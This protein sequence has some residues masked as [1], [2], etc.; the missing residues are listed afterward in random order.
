MSK[1]RLELGVTYGIIGIDQ[2]SRWLHM[3]DRTSFV[4]DRRQHPKTLLTTTRLEIGKGKR[5]RSLTAC[6]AIKT[7]NGLNARSK[8]YQHY[9][10]AAHALCIFSGID[11]SRMPR[12]RFHGKPLK[13]KRHEN[14]WLCVIQ[15][16]E[17]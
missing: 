3:F 5:Q 14:P 6:P 9:P 12:V 1:G 8:K 15:S 17:Q 13:R 7:F 16:T 2:Q 11:S 4:S 10:T